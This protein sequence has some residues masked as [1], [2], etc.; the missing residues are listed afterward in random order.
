MVRTA[1]EE[2][3]KPASLLMFLRVGDV[4]YITDIPGES[5]ETIGEEPCRKPVES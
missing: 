5:T 4:S 3:Q 2:A 1:L